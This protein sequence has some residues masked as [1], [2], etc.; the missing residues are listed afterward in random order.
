[1]KGA[2][3]PRARSRYQAT[4]FIVRLPTS[5]SGP[6]YDG[7]KEL[8]CEIQVKTILQDAWAQIDHLLMYKSQQS[9][10]E[11]ER[12]ELN[13]VSALLEV[14][15]SI[16]DRTRET[17]ELYTRE[18][19]DKLQSHAEFLGQGID[20]ETLAA[21]TRQR[22]PQVPVDRRIQE[23]LLG[24][25]DRARYRTL[26]DIEDAIVAAADAVGAYQK[27]A[28]GLFETGT[29]YIT[30]SL[31]FAD[32]GFRSTHGFSPRSRQA[33]AKYGHLVKGRAQ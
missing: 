31:G 32:E 20:R 28:P 10:P 1:M 19:E 13:N 25:L 26:Q 21:Y 33:F 6:R 29:D 22:F 15:Q 2:S 8:V 17:R 9:I 4:H 12:R 24:D 30:K 18:V 27:D 14:A 16:F 3:R 7:L 11:R 23:I 5:S